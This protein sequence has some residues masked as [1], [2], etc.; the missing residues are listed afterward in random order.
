M[1]KRCHTFLPAALIL[2]SVFT[3]AIRDTTKSNT[4]LSLNI[5]SGELCLQAHQTHIYAERGQKPSQFP[6]S[7]SEGHSMGSMVAPCD[8]QLPRRLTE[9]QSA[10]QCRRHKFE[11]WVGKIL[12]RRKWQPNSSTLTW[13]IP[14]TE[15]PGGLQSIELQESGMT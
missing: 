11:P 4:L 14:W 15:E 5:P 8:I 3:W 7:N 9:K 13:E 12:W 6:K 10:C 2:I 1:R